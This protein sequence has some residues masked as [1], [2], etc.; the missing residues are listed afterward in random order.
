MQF[1]HPVLPLAGDPSVRCTASRR[2]WPWSVFERLRTGLNHH[3]TGNLGSAIGNSSCT[4]CWRVRR[5]LLRGLVLD[6][7]TIGRGQELVVVPPVSFG[8]AWRRL[9]RGGLASEHLYE[10]LVEHPLARPSHDER[11]DEHGGRRVMTSSG[12]PCICLS[13]TSRNWLASLD[14]CRNTGRCAPRIDLL[15]N[16]LAISEPAHV[17]QATHRKFNV[18]RGTLACPLIAVEIFRPRTCFGSNN[19][20]KHGGRGTGRERSL[21]RRPL[22]CP[23]AGV[24]LDFNDCQSPEEAAPDAICSI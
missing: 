13:A 12:L 23:A 14:F 7:W 24:I 16:L 5:H 6:H 17:E 20:C 15:P 2:M 1:D 19:P 4:A 11:Y 18:S 8:L 21:H 10:L 3:L 9:L 22:T